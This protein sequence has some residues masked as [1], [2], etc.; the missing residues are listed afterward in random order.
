MSSSTEGISHLL[1]K[2]EG[3]STAEIKPFTAE[4]IWPFLS[5]DFC[6]LH[7]WFPGIDS[8]HLVEGTPGQPGLIRHCAN[9][10][11]STWAKEKLLTIDNDQKQLTYQVIDNNVGFQN[12]VATIKVS[13]LLQGIY[14]YT[15]I[16]C[17]ISVY[18]IDWCSYSCRWLRDWVVVR[19]GS[20]RG[21]EGR[22]SEGL[23]RFT[24]SWNGRQHAV[25]TRDG[26]VKVNVILVI[27]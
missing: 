19:V 17:I 8:C 14:T 24:P 12:Y 18:Y 10:S 16:V 25:C 7:K 22:R 1:A 13:P 20:G 15:Y 9:S 23:H 26:W 3:K 27:P 11:A 6:S 5:E 2:W 4:Q 21:M